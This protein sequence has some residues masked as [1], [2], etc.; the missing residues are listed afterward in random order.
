MQDTI[1]NHDSVM[2]KLF[3]LIRNHKWDTFMDEIRNNDDIDINTTDSTEHYFL[4]YAVKYNKLDVVRAL[5]NKGVNYDIVDK[6]GRSIIYIAIEYNY[7]DIVLE[8]LQHSENAIG[9]MI[10]NIIDKNGNIPLHYAIKNGNIDLIQMLMQYNSNPYTTDKNGHNSLH[11]AVLTNS[12]PIVTLIINQM[13]NLNLKNNNGETAL[14]LALNYRHNNI[15]KILLDKNADPNIPDNDNE[16]TPLHY[17]VGWDNYDM[18]LYLIKKKANIN[19]QDIYGNVPLVYCIKENQKLCFDELIK[20]PQIDVN[21]WNMY[22][23]ICLHEALDNYDNSDTSYIEA[24]IKK[25]NVSSQDSYGNTCL[26]HLVAYGLWEKYIDVLTQKKINLFAKNLDG[27]SVFDLVHEHCNPNQQELFLNMVV[28]SYINLLKKGNK[29]ENELDAMCSKSL[30]DLTSNEKVKLKEY[31]NTQINDNNKLISVCRE[32]LRNKIEANINLIKNGKIEH[33]QRSYPYDMSK[34]I[35][36]TPT[37]TINICTF[38]GSLLDVL[39]GLIYLTKKHKHV[40]AI[41][42]KSAQNNKKICDLYKTTG[43][44]LNNRCEFLNYE[45]VWVNYK[46]YVFDGFSA[47]FIKCTKSNTRFVIIPLGIELKQGCHSNYL[48]YDTKIK[49]IERFEPHGGTVPVKYDYNGPLLDDILSEF[50]GSIDPTIKYISPTDY[51]PKIG[52]ETIDSQETNKTRICDPSGFCALW[53]IWYVDN[54]L[55]YHSQ[56]R[57]EL[58]LNLFESIQI[59]NISFKNMIRNYSGIIVQKRDDLLKK[60]NMDIN[61]WLNDNY[62]SEQADLFASLIMSELNK[63]KMS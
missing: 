60:A 6:L 3:N 13:S 52:F 48:I 2:I 32:L 42:E 54:R 30:D 29:W 38:T 40:C 55:E 20:Q 39:I 33:C 49:E 37:Q 31:T 57:N 17:A 36:V 23:K 56:K 62:T 24:L 15:A 34:C 41:I 63:I 8:L 7:V 10:V 18:M 21:K 43:L 50:F 16:F 9:I 44:K 45:I 58:L 28:D 47:S 1:S 5:L 61:D 19:Q 53:S 4:T 12:V 46:M 51:I 14:H 11:L 22:G 59:S 26:H 35:H 27:V 25:S